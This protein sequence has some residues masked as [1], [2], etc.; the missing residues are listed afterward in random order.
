M[1]TFVYRIRTDG[2]RFICEA[3]VDGE[4]QRIAFQNDNVHSAEA[5]SYAL[6]GEYHD[7]EKELLQ[8]IESVAGSSA[9]RVREWRTV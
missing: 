1:D 8:V 9:R 3:Q 2:E 5:S 4:W 6:D 7:S